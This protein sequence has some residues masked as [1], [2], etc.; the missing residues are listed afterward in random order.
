MNSADKKV[1]YETDS[2]QVESVEPKDTKW[3][4]WII[5]ETGKTNR[6]ILF[7]ISEPMTIQGT[8]VWRTIG[9]TDKNYPADLVQEIQNYVPRVL[10]ALD[11]S[12]KLGVNVNIHTRNNDIAVE[13]DGKSSNI[14]LNSA[15]S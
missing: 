2:M 12:G 13:I 4:R 8:E 11:A 7:I 6:S 14:N 9:R 10:A 5:T 3:F 1:I 15:S